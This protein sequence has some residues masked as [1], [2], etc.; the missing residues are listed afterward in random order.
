MAAAVLPVGRFATSPIAKMLL[1]LLCYSV[2]LLTST[3]P[4]VCASS[5][6]LMN[7]GAV[8]GG[9]KCNRSKF[10]LT[11]SPLPSLKVAT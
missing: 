10:T 4:L 2:F 5:L 8:C 6:F 11:I 3:Q 7:S 9:T 1:N